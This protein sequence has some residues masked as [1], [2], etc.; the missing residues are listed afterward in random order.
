MSAPP[1]LAVAGIEK[2]FPGVRALDGVS[3]AVRA[4]EI[5]ALVGENGAGKSTLMRILAGVHPPDAGQIEIDGRPVVLASPAQARRQG[6]AM[7]FQ[8]TRLVPDL[9]VAQNIH[10]GH[11]PGGVLLD[12]RAMRTNA[13]ALLAR[14]GEDFDVRAPMRGRPLAERQ[15]VE[16]ARALSLAVRVLILDEPTSALTPRET[17]RLFAVLRDL[18]AQGTAI[19]F[20]SHRLPEVLALADRV[21]VLKDGRMVGTVAAADTHQDQ[22]V[23]M[24]VGR[25]VGFAFPPRAQVIGAAVLEVASLTAPGTFSGIDLT[26]HA[27]EIL[28]LGGI[29][30]S[31]QQEIVRALFG[32]MPTTGSIRLHGRP[33]APADPAEAIRAGIV[34]LPSDRRGEG[35]FLP[36]SIAQNIALPH[37]KDWSHLGVLDLR[38]ERRL[39]DEQIDGLRIRTPGRLQPVGLLSGG[40]QQKVAFARWLFSDPKVLIF[41]EPTQGVDVGSKLEIYGL[42]RSLAARGIAVMLVSSDLL[43]LIGMSDRIL[44]VADGRLVDEVSGPDASEARIVGSAVTSSPA[45]P[46]SIGHAEP[47][48]ERMVTSAGRLAARYGATLMLLVI[49]AALCIFAA[50]ATPFFWTPRNLSS[51]AI[52]TAPLIVVALGQFTVVLLGG[53]DLSVGPTISTT[54]AIASFL[55][56]TDPPLGMAGGIAITLLAGLSIGVLNGVLIERLRLPDLVTTLATFSAI[57]GVALIIRPAPGGLLDADIADALLARIAGVPVAFA[58]ALVLALLFEVMLLRGRIGLRLLATGSDQ[59]AAFV[60]GIA[61]GRVRFVAYVFC[62]VMATLAGLLVAARIGS[63]DPQAGTNFTLLS[64]T[65]VVL[66]GTSVFGGKGTATGVLIAAVLLMSVQNAMNHL[67]VSAYWQYVLTGALTLFAVAFYA[68]RSDGAAL[69]RWI[70]RLRRPTTPKVTA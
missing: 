50:T 9:D 48:Q 28:G 59:E 2:S 10:L 54:T 45:L 56:V 41:D 40:N 61:T 58:A 46:A 69:R 8:D 19:V 64:V 51:L 52:Q 38:R 26:V 21:T 11:E 68:A 4:G 63:G 66:G 44:V 37:V 22:L 34:Y 15:M 1:V 16:L 55:V 3:F 67:H 14:L 12:Y 49:T 31:G 5:H 53:I 42:I 24:M 7:V 35:M 29:A 23:Q 17:D 13:R 57:S 47:I 20:I 62:A 39:V 65:A 70:G 60:A 36:H 25:D 18:K 6:I 33:I 27:G 30:G 32:L 43:E